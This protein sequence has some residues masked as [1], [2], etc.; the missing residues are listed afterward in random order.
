MDSYGI[1][2]LAPAGIALILAF[3]TRDAL[4]S[5]LIGVIVGVIIT[6][7]NVVTGFT[8]IV[9]SALGNAD[10]IWVIAIEVFIGIMVAYF[11]KSGAIKAF[12]DIVGKKDL[13]R[14][15]AAGLA[16]CLGMFI[17]FSDYF[18]PLYV[19]NIMRPITDK[20]RVSREKLA[21]ICDSTS[22]P[23]CCLIPF[24]SWGVYVAGLLV[25]LGPI[26]DTTTAQGIIVHAVPFNFYCILA[27]VL[28]GLV[29]FRVVPDFGPMRKAEKRAY[30]EGK[31]IADGAS[32]LLSQELDNIKPKEGIKP[33]LILNFLMPAVIIIGITVGSYIVTGSA[34]T[35]EAFVV[36]VAY[37]FVVMLIQKMATL[38]EMVDT[39]VEGIKSVMSAML[40]LALA[41]CINAIST[42]LGTANFVI[43]VTESWMTPMLLVTLTFLICAFI[44]FF[45]GTAW[46][47]YAIM[48]PIAIPLAF[49]V[50]GGEINSIVYASVAAVLG[51]GCF[52]DHCSPLSDTTILS[53]LAAGSDH[54]DHTRTQMVYA[55]T[56]AIIS[57]IGFLIVGAALE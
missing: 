17:W 52:G 12:A 54:I 36:A 8:G 24:T 16:W 22:A 49:N 38:K 46:G 44:S 53:S 1:L 40:I 11:Q 33:N 6:G 29:S 5:I 51:G 20:A 26:A 25:G 19:G 37:Q 27:L 21:Y 35:L 2:S 56:C 14:R 55:V 15:G 28:S 42:E 31:V 4:I 7:Q 57:C 13:K 23:I 3:V 30:E 32:P 45:T 43:S 9:Q 39:A 50:T 34:L 47:V 10:F 48:T 18:S 41:Y